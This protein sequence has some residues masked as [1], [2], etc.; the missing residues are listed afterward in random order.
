MKIYEK[1]LD[2]QATVITRGRVIKISFFRHK[3][4]DV[5]VPLYMNLSEQLKRKNIDPTCIIPTL[6]AFIP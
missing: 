5:V 1:F 2:N 6:L 3:M 4:H